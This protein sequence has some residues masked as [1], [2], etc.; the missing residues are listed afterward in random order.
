MTCELHGLFLNE[1]L[2]YCYV[3]CVIFTNIGVSVLG[4]VTLNLKKTKAG[5][6]KCFP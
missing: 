6:V 1:R 5:K 2:I 3:A 4:S